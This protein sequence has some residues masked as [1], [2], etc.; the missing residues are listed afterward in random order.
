VRIEIQQIVADDEFVAFRWTARGTHRGP[1][2]GVRASGRTVSLAG[3]TL[4]RVVDGRF[5][6]SWVQTDSL[7][8][9]RQLGLT[10]A[11]ASAT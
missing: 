7:G 6:E 8:L 5:H 1:L 4:H 11:P 9:A 2:L 10:L 3:H